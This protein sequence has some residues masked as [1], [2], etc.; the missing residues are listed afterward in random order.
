MRLKDCLT[1]KVH[2]ILLVDRTER[3]L[4]CGRDTDPGSSQAIQPYMGDAV[5]GTAHSGTYLL[6]T[7]DRE[8]A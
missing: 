4:F 7:L 6:I 1:P 5:M 3:L 8:V 2:N